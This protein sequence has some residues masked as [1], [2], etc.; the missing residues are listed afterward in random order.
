ML[1]SLVGIIASSGGAAGGGS[2]ES[3]ASIT[4]AGGEA[5]ITFTSIPSTYASLQIR[6][7]TRSNIGTPAIISGAV[8]RFNNYNETTAY[9][10]IQ[11]DGA[12]ATA[13]GGASSTN[14]QQFIE[15]N[16]AVT[17]NTFGAMIM[18]I[19]DYASTTRFKTVRVFTGADANGTGRVGLFSSLFQSTSAVTSIRFYDGEG[20]FK[21]GTTF[22]LYGIKGA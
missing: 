18:D 14:M 19:H 7:I 16:N 6:A 21:A 3:I 10:S 1:N 4:A 20:E 12:S 22:A 13:T 17:A 8:F 2:Y 15:P 9:H 5:N 11:G